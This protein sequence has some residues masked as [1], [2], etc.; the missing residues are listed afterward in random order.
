MDFSGQGSNFIFSDGKRKPVLGLCLLLG[1]C[2]VEYELFE[3][4][5]CFFIS[6][7]DSFSARALSQG[8]CPA[9]FLSS[10]LCVHDPVG[11]GWGPDACR[12]LSV[13]KRSHSEIATSCRQ[14]DKRCRWVS[15]HCQRGWWVP[16]G[17]S[18]RRECSNS[19]ETRGWGNRKLWLEEA[20]KMSCWTSLAE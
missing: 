12:V 7:T 19:R 15:S 6:S 13:D 1:S 11:I 16:G 20:R 9:G 10:Y 17:L 18:V 5:G 3:G 4:Q 2:S 8:L 14:S